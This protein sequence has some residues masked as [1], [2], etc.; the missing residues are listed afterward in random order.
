MFAIYLMKEMVLY[1]INGLHKW[2]VSYIRFTSDYL[3]SS[4]II[5]AAECFN[6]VLATSLTVQIDGPL[7]RMGKCESCTI[8]REP[9]S[10]FIAHNQVTQ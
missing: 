2:N 5:V 1:I 3:L 9:L 10:A 6:L 7:L 4:E 8:E